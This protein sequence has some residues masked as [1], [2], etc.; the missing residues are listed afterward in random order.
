MRQDNQ[1]S[2]WAV[3]LAYILGDNQ[4]EWYYEVSVIRYD[5]YDIAGI[6]YHYMFWYMHTLIFFSFIPGIFHL[7]T[8]ISVQ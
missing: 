3:R 5:N 7:R 4:R 6:T 2:V 1:S 8:D